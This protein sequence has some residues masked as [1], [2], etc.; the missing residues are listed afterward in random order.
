VEIPAS[1]ETRGHGTTSNA[2]WWKR[3]LPDLLQ[4]LAAAAR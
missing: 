4:P 3:Y 2:K 1:D